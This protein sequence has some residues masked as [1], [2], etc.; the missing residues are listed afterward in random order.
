MNEQELLLLLYVSLLWSLPWKGF[1]LWKAAKNN[2]KIWFIALFVV[3]TMA[4]LEIFYIFIFS[5]KK[6]RKNILQKLGIKK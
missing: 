1:A 5:Q 2:Q 6:E 3:N 4:L